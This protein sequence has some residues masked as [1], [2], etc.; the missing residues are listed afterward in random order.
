M[1]ILALKTTRKQRTELTHS[2]LNQG[3]ID[4]DTAAT[5]LHRAAA[6][7]AASIV[8]SH[9]RFQLRTKRKGLISEIRQKKKVILQLI[10]IRRTGKIAKVLP[11]LGN[12]FEFVP[13]SWISIYHDR[14][15]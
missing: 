7:A 15:S 12:W 8:N 13:F 3:V 9:S 11:I 14:K 4:C 10:S 5:I 2:F 6:A 1:E